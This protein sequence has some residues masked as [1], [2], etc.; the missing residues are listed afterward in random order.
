[1]AEIKQKL[2]KE[3][4]SSELSGPVE[5]ISENANKITHSLKERAHSN[6]QKL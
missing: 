2:S 1:M 3:E 5:D 4:R 6:M